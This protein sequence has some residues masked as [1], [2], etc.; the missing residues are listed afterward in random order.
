MEKFDPL[1]ILSNS[2]RRAL[3]SILRELDG[4][5]ELREVV[6]R[7]AELEQG[8][9]FDRKLRK[10]VYV[11]LIQTHIPKMESAGLIEHDGVSDVISLLEIPSAYRQYLDI[12]ERGEVL[13][14]LCY[15]GVSIAGLGLGIYYQNQL[16]ST[17]SFF[18]SVTSGLQIFQMLTS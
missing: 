10:S 18:F 2:R 3:I 14:S 7:I 16:A 15:F 1:Q 8:P 9:D 6:R 4:R 17:V 11:S 13:R 5:A 12:S